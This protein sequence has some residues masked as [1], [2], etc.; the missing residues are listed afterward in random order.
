MR[1]SDDD[2]TVSVFDDGV[3]LFR[4]RADTAASKPHADVVALP[5]GAGETAGR[6]LVL[7]APHDHA[8]HLGLFFC[9]KVVDGVNC[10]ESE[11]LAA[12]GKLHGFADG[13]EYRVADHGDSVAIEHDCEWQTSEGDPLLGDTR[14]VTVHEPDADG[15][16]VRWDQRLTARGGNRYLGSESVHGY[17]NGLSLRFAR[18]MNDG[19]ETEGF[20]LP[21]TARVDDPRNG[22]GRW[23]DYSGPLDGGV[24]RT[25]VHTAGITVIEHPETDGATNWW[26]TDEGFGFLAANPTLD[27]RAL[28]SGETLAWTWGLWVHPDTPD[29]ERVEA[30]CETFL[31]GA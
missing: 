11:A 28:A 16:F 22:T 20:L 29:R 15:Y 18:G 12:A 30:A 2:G 26:G 4:Y 21:D 23:C 1:A 19:P 6:N 9:Q 13:G 17:Y 27:V 25:D 24:G 5:A 31:D 10:W 14:T 8:W 7:A 3:R